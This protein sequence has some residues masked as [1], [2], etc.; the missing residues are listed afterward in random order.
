[1]GLGHDARIE[2]ICNRAYYKEVELEEVF[3]YL[4]KLP[5][6]S[7]D[8]KEV[9]KLYGNGSSLTERQIDIACNRYAQDH[10]GRKLM[11]LI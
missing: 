6:I 11:I 1:M 10:T 8:L 4:Q 2:E 5:K 3:D 9:L 7:K